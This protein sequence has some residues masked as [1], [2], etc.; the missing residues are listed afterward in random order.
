MTKNR[1]LLIVALTGLLGA[2]ACLAADTDVAPVS[3]LV[4]GMKALR[5]KT[6]PVLDFDGN[7]PTKELNEPSFRSITMRWIMPKLFSGKPQDVRNYF[8]TECKSRG[9]E[10]SAPLCK[11]L[12][13]ADRPYFYGAM[14]TQSMETGHQVTVQVLEPK[15]DKGAPDYLA[16]LKKLGILSA[17]EIKELKARADQAIEEQKAKAEQAKA[18]AVQR[19]EA[20]QKDMGKRGIKV[21]K[22]PWSPE[23][24]NVTPDLTGFI[25]DVAD[26]RIKIVGIVAKPASNVMVSNT[27]L[28]WDKT[29][30]WYVCE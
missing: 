16:A 15:D 19:Y 4:D 6:G 8:A 23:K 3:S 28:L 25:E 17:A 29:A 26:D 9:G 30:N 21:C 12:N 14:G 1:N 24:Q 11:D 5:K 13:D 27:A 18:R 2:Q 22:G 7:F 20:L 10:Y